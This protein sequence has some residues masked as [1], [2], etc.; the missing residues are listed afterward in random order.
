[1]AA[2]RTSLVDALAYCLLEALAA[3][4]AAGQ[5]RR[6]GV[7]AAVVARA[8]ARLVL[9]LGLGLCALVRRECSGPC[10]WLVLRLR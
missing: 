4:G 9:G 7:L 1:M 5:E 10:S 3:V 6:E 2:A 8:R